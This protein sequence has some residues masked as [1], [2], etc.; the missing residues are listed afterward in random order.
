[1]TGV[2]TDPA[3]P[4]ID[5]YLHGAPHLGPPNPR[6][7]QTPTVFRSPMEFVE[8]A[9]WLMK[10]STGQCRCQYCEPN[11]T[12]TDINR[13]LNHNV[14]VDDSE[15]Q[16]DGSGT[17]RASSASRRRGASA[18]TRRPRRARRDRSPPIMAKDYR[19]GIPGLDPGPGP[20]PAS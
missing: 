15:P 12:Q 13:R 18:G 6:S 2:D 10:G 9:I 17:V 19:V 11:Q 16:S 4:R 7:Q 1:M 5:A 20:G 8:H 3:N 14:E